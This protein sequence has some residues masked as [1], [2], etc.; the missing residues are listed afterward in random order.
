MVDLQSMKE[1]LFDIKKAMHLL[2]SLPTSYQTLSKILLHRDNNAVTYN[3]V[4]SA[5]L[6]DEVEQEML[7]FSRPFPSST[8]LTVIRGQSQPSS[9]ENMQHT[10]FKR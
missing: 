6:V 9:H 8:A 7:S 2:H 4:V 10:G 1:E 3:E 5:L